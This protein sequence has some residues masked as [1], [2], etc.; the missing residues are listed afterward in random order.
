[1]RLGWNLDTIDFL[2]SIFISLSM[3]LDLHRVVIRDP[4]HRAANPD[5]Y[6]V[7]DD[8]DQLGLLSG[9]HCLVMHVSALF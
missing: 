6:L 5:L 4:G 3:S 9:R 8:C 1:M 7:A 2:D